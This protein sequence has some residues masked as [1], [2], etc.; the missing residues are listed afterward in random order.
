MNQNK[1]PAYDI[2]YFCQKWGVILNMFQKII[3]VY[4]TVGKHSDTMFKLL[5]I[6]VY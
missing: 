2:F 5:C 6:V 3:N 1:N 4:Y